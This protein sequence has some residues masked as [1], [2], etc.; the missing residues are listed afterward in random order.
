[1]SAGSQPTARSWATTSCYF[2]SV[3]P[4][5]T[6]SPNRK[7]PII[8]SLHYA[9]ESQK[10]FNESYPCLRHDIHK[11]K[12][13]MAL[14]ASR[15]PLPSA[16]PTAVP[17]RSRTLASSRLTGCVQ[18]GC[19]GIHHNYTVTG[20][21]PRLWPEHRSLVIP[22]RLLDELSE[23]Y[24]IDVDH[25]HISGFSMGGHGTWSL[26]LRTPDRSAALMPICSSVDPALARNIKFVSQWIYHGEMDPISPI[27][28]RIEMERS[29]R[30]AGA[31]GVH[32]TRYANAE[33]D[34]WHNA[35][36]DHDL[37]SWM[38]EKRRPVKESGAPS[39]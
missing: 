28:E 20:H 37:F 9:G 10:G 34:S 38:P 19:R 39:G 18:A 11:G 31:D 13:G 12:L 3:P 15:S 25:I 6:L 24:N 8:L 22:A 17:L 23:A 35:Y 32:F 26:G 36:S 33:H 30:T 27:E 2:L 21:A 16:S 5:Y 14:R 4:A 1:M 7:W 29:L